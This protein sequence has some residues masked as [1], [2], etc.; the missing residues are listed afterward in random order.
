MT[1]I[2]VGAKPKPFECLARFWDGK[3]ADE[4]IIKLTINERGPTLMLGEY[5]HWP[6]KDLRIMRDQAGAGALLLQSAED[7]QMRI[8]IEDPQ[9]QRILRSRCEDLGKRVP[10]GGLSKLLIAAVAAAAS[11]AV[12]ILFLVPLLADQL[13][14]VLPPEGEK[15]LGDHTLAQVSSMLSENDV[16]PL[17]SCQT[18]D[19]TAALEEI[20]SRVLGEE[21]L[22]YPLS[23]HVLDHPMVN[24]FA[25]P[26][27][28]IVFF[29]GLLEAAETSDEVAA[30]F[31]HELGHVVARD[32]AR[33]ALRSA[34]SIGILGLLLGDFAGGTAVLWMA[35]RL[36]QAD[37]SQEA[38]TAADIYASERL[39]AAK[40]D[41]A[42]LGTFFERML[43]DH[44]DADG[45]VQHFLSHPTFADRIE[46]AKTAPKP[47]GMTPAL[48]DE[49]FA[50]LKAICQVSEDEQEG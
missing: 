10:F 18:P 43:E 42:A 34:G 21:S 38:E 25:L 49:A 28:H 39:N 32:P 16:L 5:G 27:G 37:Y 48:N 45:L 24:A 26:G 14:K 4:R 40:M 23:V 46:A 33:I 12:M 41:P 47:E 17:R 31:A 1:I 6:L 29:N 50:A 44:G 2:R 36:V 3:T 9:A 20:T 15:A 30:V 35:E 13:A 11:V 19:G 22:P 7:A 8:E